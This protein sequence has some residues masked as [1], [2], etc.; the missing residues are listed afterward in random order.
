MDFAEK[1]EHVLLRESVKKIGLGFGHAYFAEK[2]KRGEKMDSAWREL[3][4]GGFIGANIPEVYGGAGMGL[5]ELALVCEEMA[6]AGCP[7]LMLVVTPAICA[8]I[9]VRHGTE[10]QKR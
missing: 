7:V 5:Y 4:K 9:L 1:A 3:A 2:A 8:S 10:E 6:A